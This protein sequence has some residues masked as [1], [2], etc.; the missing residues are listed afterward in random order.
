[1]GFYTLFGRCINL[2]TVYEFIQTSS[3]I[4]SSDYTYQG[5]SGLWAPNQWASIKATGTQTDN[6]LDKLFFA[7]FNS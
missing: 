5:A 3:S 2:A 6:G 4:T 1:M 7:S